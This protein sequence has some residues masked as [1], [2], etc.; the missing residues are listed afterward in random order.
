[1]TFRLSVWNTK[2]RIKGSPDTGTSGLNA[3]LD[4]AMQHDSKET[5]F[6]IEKGLYKN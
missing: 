5:E 3:V 2:L 1:M 6:K 4:T